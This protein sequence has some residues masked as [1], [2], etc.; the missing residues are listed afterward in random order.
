MADELGLFFEFLF[1]NV[2]HDVF[3]VVEKL[4]QY[5]YR[6][7]VN[8]CLETFP[9]R[10]RAAIQTLV[11]D[12]R[13]STEDPEDP[14]AQSSQHQSLGLLVKGRWMFE[15]RPVETLPNQVTNLKI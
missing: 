10:L 12:H 13:S 2:H 7:Y 1:S 15:T 11:T 9:F 6:A 4:K 5:G 3:Q 14:E 8:Q